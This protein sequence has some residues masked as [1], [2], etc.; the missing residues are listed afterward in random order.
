M[1]LYK[2]DQSRVHLILRRAREAVAPLIREET[3]EYTGNFMGFRMTDT[4]KPV[5]SAPHRAPDVANNDSLRLKLELTRM[6]ALCI[7]MS[8]E[9]HLSRASCLSGELQDLEK[10]IDRTETELLI[11]KQEER[12]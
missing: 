4:Q 9:A 8:I 1:T 6:Q 12:E 7:K 5:A 3:S 10:E 2:A 11:M